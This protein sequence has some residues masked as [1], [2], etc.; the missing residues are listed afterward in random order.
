MILILL[1]ATAVSTDCACFDCDFI[2]IKL[3]IG[4]IYK[5][6]ARN[7]NV[8]LANEA[9]TDVNGMHKVNKTTE[10][11]Q[12]LIFENQVCHYLPTGID[13][14]FPKVYHFDVRNS[15]LK[16]V[17]SEQMRMFPL[18]KHLYI[19]NNPIE[20]LPDH[21]FSHNPF[22]EFI[23]LND[24]RI[25]QVGVGIFEPL[26][27]LVSLS[28]ERNDC[29]DGYAMEEETLKNLIAEVGRKCTAS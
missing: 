18:L 9:L 22:L 7:V 19:R 27:R 11:V 4:G 10:D 13:L 17:T 5:C 6:K 20:V 28:I 15:G 2:Y 8:K 12:I 29:I 23:N 25:K 24:N 1:L 3:M 16:A 26:T 21:L 14:H